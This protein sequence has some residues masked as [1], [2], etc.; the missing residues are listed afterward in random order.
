MKKRI[1]STFLTLALLLT[2]LPT[3][4]M[5]EDGQ[6]IYT[7][8]GSATGDGSIANPYG[9][10]GDALKKAKELDGHNTIVI[11]GGTAQN[12]D[13]ST[14]APLII[15]TP[16]TIEGRTEQNEEGN[17]SF[18]I[19]SGGI[20]LGTDVTMKNVALELTNRY[21]NAIFVN[22]HKFAAENVVRGHGSRE[23]HLFAG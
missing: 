14:S 20:V 8:E 17:A 21:H 13:T 15:D 11:L 19:R 3:A 2:L 9:H 12:D 6:T 23:V 5:A 7:K 4:V 22:G 18:N 10:F 16:V 1:L